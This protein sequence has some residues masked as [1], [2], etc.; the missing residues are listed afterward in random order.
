MSN[1]YGIDLGTRNLK[2]YNKSTGEV[3]RIK[4]AIAIVEKDQMYAYGDDAYS[5]YEKAP[6]SIEVS[7]PIVGGVIAD[8]DNMQTML[9]ASREAEGRRHC[10]DRPHRHYRGG[11]E[12][13]FRH[14][15]EIENQIPQRDSLRETPGGCPR[16]GTGYYRTHRRHDRGYRG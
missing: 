16:H 9:F 3:T 13:V 11:E 1:A 7:F 4:N 12:G 5:M 6:E 10:H 2:I 15:Y 8:F 14:V